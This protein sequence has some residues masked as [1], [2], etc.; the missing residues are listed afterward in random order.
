LKNWDKK[1]VDDEQF[2]KSYTWDGKDLNLEFEIDFKAE[3]LG[4]AHQM[5]FGAYGLYGLQ[6]PKTTTRVET[7]STDG[8]LASQ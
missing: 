5:R 1:G 4:S 3:K 8:T 6:R 7:S 2:F